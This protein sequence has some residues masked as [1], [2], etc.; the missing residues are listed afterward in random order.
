MKLIVGLGNPG[1]KYEHTR[2]NMGFDA[3]DLFADLAMIDVDKESF[4]GLVGRGKVFN[5]D[6]FLLKPQTFMNLSGESVAELVHYFKIDI[7]D[8]VIVYD[9]MALPTGK[10]RLRANGSSGGH[11]GM[12][13]II[14]HLSTENIKRIRVGIGEPPFDA[15]DYVLSKPTKDEQVLIDDA[16]K[17]AVEAL[18]VFIKNNFDVAMNRFN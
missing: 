8:I 2:H 17:E 12:Q 9:E 4:K 5:E 6:V 16:I 13:N 7:N 3:L 14:D 10:I 18:K 11:K 15:I 1:K